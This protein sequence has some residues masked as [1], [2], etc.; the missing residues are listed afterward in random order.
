[1]G[2]SSHVTNLATTST[3]AS[4]AI[5]IELG[6]FS[7]NH[8]YSASR[9]Q[10]ITIT[11]AENPSTG[12]SWNFA[13]DVNHDCGPEDAFT[14]TTEFTPGANPK[15][16]VGVGGTR[17]F[18]IKPTSKAIVGSTCTLGFENGRSWEMSE[19]W[20]SHPAKE[21]KVSIV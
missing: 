9:G 12:Y 2:S 3:T 4:A 19:N 17:T 16:F 10:I 13:G 21:I 1:M 15:H 5:A 8:V 11:G 6:S 18:T 14:M 7:E 20:R